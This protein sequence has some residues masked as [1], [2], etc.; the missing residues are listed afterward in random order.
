M[1]PDRL[2]SE[3]QKTATLNHH[4]LSAL[5]SAAKLCCISGQI[6]L[7]KYSVCQTGDTVNSG[8]LLIFKKQK[9]ARTTDTA[10]FLSAVRSEVDHVKQ[11]IYVI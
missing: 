2:N 5:C 8:V 1:L 11:M 9:R 4:S 6:F 10:F 3:Q 7:G